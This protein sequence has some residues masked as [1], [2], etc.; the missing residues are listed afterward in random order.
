MIVFNRTTDF[1]AIIA[2]A[3]K[4]D[5]AE[6]KLNKAQKLLSS[7]GLK[8]IFFPDIFSGDIFPFFAANKNIRLK[9]LQQALLHPDVKIIWA[10]RGGYGC[11]QIIFD[12]L[13]LSPVGTKILIGYSDITALHSLF[14][15]HYKIPTL[16]ASVLTSVL[17]KQQHDFDLIMNALAGG[18]IKIKLEPVNVL[19]HHDV[20]GE[21]IGGNLTVFCNLLGTKLHPVTNDK[22]LL[23]EDVNESAYRIHRYLVHLKNAGIFDSLKAV[24]FADFIH[25]DQD[26]QQTIQHF[27]F[28]EINNIPAYH[29][30]GIGH[31]IVNY[32][33]VLGELAWIKDQQLTVKNPFR[34]V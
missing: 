3:S 20:S 9:N 18:E 25:K 33:V 27:C 5:E 2:P 15:Q 34:L 13:D 21:I 14:N 6:E 32:P 17:S 24:I 19:D 22:I 29:A 28:S 7:Q 12:C 8:S 11:S 26:I 31:G 10:F 16:H 23:L 30:G 4:C 1:V